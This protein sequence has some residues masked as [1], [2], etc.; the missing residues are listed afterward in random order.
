M[1]HMFT[2]VQWNFP[3]HV[4]ASWFE[5]NQSHL[6]QPVFFS[7]PQKTN[8]LASEMTTSNSLL[9]AVPF[10]IRLR[11][12]ASKGDHKAAMDAPRSW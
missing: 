9:R 6:Q 8:K 10:E 12:E 11:E 4:R 3:Y 2:W 5:I 1:G 7:P